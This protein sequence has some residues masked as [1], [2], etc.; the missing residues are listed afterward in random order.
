MNRIA[1]FV[2][3]IIFTLHGFSQNKQNSL[4]LVPIPV[5]LKTGQGNYM[6]K[7]SSVIEVTTNDAEVTRVA[8]YLSKRLYPATGIKAA[9]TTKKSNPSGTGTIQFS[10]INDKIL[11]KEGY[12]LEV[13]PD[14]VTLKANAPAGLFYGVQTLLQLFPKEIESRL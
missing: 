11:G 14:L 13:T 12:S 7:P 6:F 10:I 2:F 5:S 4:A 1:C 9:V 3:L 8:S